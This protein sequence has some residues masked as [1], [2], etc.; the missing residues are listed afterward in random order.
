MGEVWEL[1]GCETMS[2][3]ELDGLASL[4]DPDEEGPLTRAEIAAVKASPVL[5]PWLTTALASYGPFALRETL[6]GRD[7]AEVLAFLGARRA[8]LRRMAVGA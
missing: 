1:H 6:A 2:P 8:E 3:N 5:R 4:M 7:H